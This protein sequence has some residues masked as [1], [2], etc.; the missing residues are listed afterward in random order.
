MSDYDRWRREA[1]RTGLAG[2]AAVAF[3]RDAAHR[4]RVTVDGERRTYPLAA[5][6]E[7]LT[8]RPIGDVLDPTVE[9]VR[10]AVDDRLVE[11]FRARHAAR[12]DGAGLWNGATYALAST[13]RGPPFRL[14]RS[15]FFSGLSTTEALAEELYRALFEAG[16]AC[17]ASD[18]AVRRAV[19]S[20]DLPRRRRVAPTASAF[21]TDDP[22]PTHLGAGVLP[23]FEADD[24]YATVL[25]R[26][27][28]DVAH[29]PGALAFPGAGIVAPDVAGDP[30]SLERCLLAE[31]SEEFFD[32]EGDDPLGH[33]GVGRLR[34]LL[35]RGDAHLDYTGAGVNLV[36]GNGL[37]C[38]LLFVGSPTFTRYLREASRPNWERGGLQWVSLDEADRLA[39]SDS[40]TLV[41]HAALCLF[42]GVRRLERGYG[43]ET[44]LDVQRPTP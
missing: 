42:E 43:V 38:A 9:G 11:R 18:A 21:F 29:Y 25:A 19:R 37:L 8:P 13:R 17:D 39:A 24:G 44:P 34:T 3:Y 1:V 28:A 15:D 26:R 31:F 16:V 30:P 5:R 35:D 14:V 2:R 41:P 40:G 12:S 33:E 32:T 22:S 20:A 27:S 36:G 23:V 6:R 10:T 4:Y 7:W